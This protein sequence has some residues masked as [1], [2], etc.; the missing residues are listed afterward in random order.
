ME[1]LSTKLIHRVSIENYSTR[2]CV[3]RLNKAFASG[4]SVFFYVHGIKYFPLQYAYKEKVV[5]MPN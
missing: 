5:P 3:A 4:C 1:P 2:L